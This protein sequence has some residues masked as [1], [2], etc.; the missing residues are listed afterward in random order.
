MARVHRDVALRVGR[1]E[2][3]AHD[4]LLAADCGKDVHA[5]IDLGFRHTDEVK[6]APDGEHRQSFFGHHLQPDKVE[7]VVGA[8]RQQ[9]AYGIDRSLLLV[10]SMTSV[11]PNP[12]AA[13]SRF[14]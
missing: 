6:R 4:A 3:H 2:V 10:E 7:D 9:F 8:S 13:S 12:R 1:A 11:A 5:N 14:G